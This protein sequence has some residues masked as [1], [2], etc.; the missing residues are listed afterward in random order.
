MATD[1][2]KGYQRQQPKPFSTVPFGRDPDFVDRPE[3]L[4]WI[5][6]KCDGPA[7]RAALI[8]I[9]GIGYV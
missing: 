7:S 9:G 3:I 5:G 6:K 8:G 4:A 2:H 1:L